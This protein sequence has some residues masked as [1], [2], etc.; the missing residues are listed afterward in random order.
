MLSEIIKIEILKT[1]KGT[2]LYP[3]EKTYDSKDL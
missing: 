2:V 3:L 1:A